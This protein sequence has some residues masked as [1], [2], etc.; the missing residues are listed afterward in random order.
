MV[1]PANPDLDRYP[2]FADALQTAQQGTLEPGDAI[3]IP[4][5]WWRSWISQ[6]IPM[7]TETI[8]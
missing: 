8:T 3:Y 4:F 6:S 1:D 7:S 5:M 2:R